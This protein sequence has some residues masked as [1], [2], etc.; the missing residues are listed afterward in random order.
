MTTRPWKARLVTAWWFIAVLISG[1]VVLITLDRTTERFDNLVYDLLLRAD[2]APP[3]DSILLVAIDDESL[4]RVGRWPWSRDTHARLI[5]ALGKAKPRAIAYDVLFPEPSVAADDTRLGDAMARAQSVF[6]PLSFVAPGQN[7]AP[8]QALLPIAPV[9]EGAR[10]IGHVNLDVDADGRVRSTMLAFNDGERVWDHMMALV[11]MRHHATAPAG[12][13]SAER[14]SP[15]LIPF[16]G[17]AGHWPSVSAAAVLGGEVPAEILADRL[18]I[19]GAT[20]QTLGDYH[21]VPT[22]GLMAGAEIQAHLLAGLLNG[23]MISVPGLA[24]LLAFGLIPVWIALLAFRRFPLPAVLPVLAAII[25][26]V[27]LA[28]AIF[29]L[30]ARVW[31]PPGAS[32]TGLCVSYPLWAWRQLAS[33][34]MFMRGELM[35]FRKEAALLPDDAPEAAKS[36]ESDSVIDS[37]GQAITNARELRRFIA[38]SF[39]QL[40]DATLVTDMTGRVTMSNAAATALFASFMIPE[41]ERLN[42]GP[43]LSRFRDGLHGSSLAF[44]I[45]PVQS[46]LSLQ[47]GEK[48]AVTADG[49]VFAIRSAAQVSG[50]GAQ[51]GWI[52]RFVDVSEAKAAQRQRETILQLLTHDL[53][54]PQASIL[55]V[56]ETA[57]PAQIDKQIASR[58]RNYAQRSLG[59]ADGFVRLA[60]AETLTYAFEEV[61]LADILMDAIDD[62]WT[63]ITAKSIQVQSVGQ[64]VQLLVSGE[65]SLLTQVLVNI[66][67]NAVKYSGE[68]TSITCVLSERQGKD[69][70]LLA[71][72]AIT[73]E[74]PGFAPEYRQ[75]IFEH[76]QRGP[77]RGGGRKVDG[78]GLGL[79]LVHTVI[80]RHKGEI[81]CDSEPGR[82]S[83]FTVLLPMTADN[84]R[85]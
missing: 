19:V 38:D 49:R 26:L 36:G 27:L 30:F 58:I 23:R 54:S 85:G 84:N 46:G 74:G 79:S 18:I 2:R 4:G 41:I 3:A 11:R 45:E 76:F 50:G 13:S 61:N 12:L 80:T 52:L 70:R 72:C 39:D 20:A 44:P 28:S 6:V 43:L 8:V 33:A 68:G 16:S 51:T 48:E 22:G 62:L 9:R 15:R 82:G 47:Q 78:L 35:R 67:G 1:A 5:D 31:L 14:Q 60:R 77:I 24:P 83:T 32:L 65:R 57:D 37:L 73:D 10:G 69:G 66:I 75:V 17:T 63:Q 59:L 29:L 55:A 81:E 42:V 34:D 21:L 56:L 40:P 71:S 64:D 25:L 53:R 7:G